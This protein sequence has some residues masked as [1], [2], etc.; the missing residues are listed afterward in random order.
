MPVCVAAFSYILLVRWL[1]FVTDKRQQLIVSVSLLHD[2]I[3]NFI[4][5]T[6][7]N[8]HSAYACR[9]IMPDRLIRSEWPANGNCI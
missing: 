5:A 1:M 4:A 7:V 3:A 6:I 2:S 9:R 8:T